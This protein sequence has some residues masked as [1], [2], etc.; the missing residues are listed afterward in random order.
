MIVNYTDSDNVNIEEI[1]SQL[2]S[3]WDLIIIENCI[4]CHLVQFSLML[5]RNGVFEALSQNE[6]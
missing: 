5:S 1:T 4:S 3:N 6:S 2:S